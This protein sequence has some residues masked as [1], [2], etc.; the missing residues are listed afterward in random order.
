MNLESVF[1]LKGRT[2]LVTGSSRG[3]G[4]SIAEGL[5]GAGAR[6]ILH[7]MTQGAARA[8]Q[9]RIAN[10]GGMA[11]ELAVDLSGPGAGRDLIE[12]AEAIAPVDILVINASAQINATLIDLMPNDLAFQL[13]VNL[14]STVDM[15]Q[16]VLPRMAARKW[17][18]VVSIGSVNQLRPKSIVTAYAATKAAQHNLI[19]SQARDYARDNV[20]LNTLA[21]GLIDTDRNAHR[22]VEDPEGWN[23]YVSALNWMGRAGQPDEMVGAAVFLA[24]E[25][26]SFMTGETIFLTG[27]Y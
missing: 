20:L 9:E 16:S 22:R 25:A 12:H 15:L 2:A 18:R 14:G 26:C 17:G 4:A 11:D 27:G 1:G 19:Q 3:I 6:V 13:A 10:A 23:E 24:S 21:P 7:G 8:V 5:A